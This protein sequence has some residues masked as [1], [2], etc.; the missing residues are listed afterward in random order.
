MFSIESKQATA[1][2][3]IKV[4]VN[5]VQETVFDNEDYMSQN[6]DTFF[7]SAEVH[8]IGGANTSGNFDGYM[9][10]FCFIDGTALDPTSFGEF[11]TATG[12]WKPKRIGTIDN[13]W[14]SSYY[15]NFNDR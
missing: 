14:T 3:R 7:N 4:Y 2:N 11:D 8:S 13:A 1:L 10:E 15:L 12:I 6:T 5:G 9:A